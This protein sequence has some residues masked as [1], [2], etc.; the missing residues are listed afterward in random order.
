MIA[1][2]L[3]FKIKSMQAVTLMIEEKRVWRCLPTAPVGCFLLFFLCFERLILPNTTLGQKKVR[4]VSVQAIGRC[5]EYHQI[6]GKQTLGKEVA[7]RGQSRRDE[8]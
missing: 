2:S 7:G 4:K 1:I 8:N 5:N 6:N 3:D